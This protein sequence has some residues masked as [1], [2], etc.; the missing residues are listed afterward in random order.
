MNIIIDFIVMLTFKLRNNPE[1][2]VEQPVATFFSS[3]QFISA[4]VD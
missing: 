2:T 3:V 4:K 1:Q